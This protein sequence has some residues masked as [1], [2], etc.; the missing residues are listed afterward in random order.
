LYPSSSLLLMAKT[1]AHPAARSLCD[2]WPSCFNHTSKSQCFIFKDYCVEKL[3]SRY[4][5]LSH[6]WF[7]WY[8]CIGCYMSKE[9]RGRAYCNDAIWQYSV[10]CQQMSIVCYICYYISVCVIVDLLSWNLCVTERR[11]CCPCAISCTNV[12]VV[13]ESC[14]LHNCQL[15]MAARAS[16]ISHS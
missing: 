13:S 5:K 15:T 10:L 12:M 3:E 16:F 4:A 2:S 9:H 1:V 8:H 14:W 11:I 6:E 7:K